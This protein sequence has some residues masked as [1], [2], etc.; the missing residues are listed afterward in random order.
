VVDLVVELEDGVHQ[1][2]RAARPARKVQNA[3]LPDPGKVNI[4]ATRR[5]YGRRKILHR[6]LSPSMGSP[7]NPMSDDEL[8]KNFMRPGDYG[9]A[10]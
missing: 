10:T 2:L 1:H 6:E 3:E 8:E 9:V 7:Q 5:E 4:T